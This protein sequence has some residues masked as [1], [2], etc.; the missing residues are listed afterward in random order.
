MKSWKRIISMMIGIVIT[1]TPFNSYASGKLVKSY[2]DKDG[3]YTQIVD[4][5]FVF[6][7]GE[8]VR[9]GGRWIDMNNA[10]YFEFFQFDEYGKLTKGN[11]TDRSSGALLDSRLRTYKWA[12][13][14][15]EI[16]EIFNGEY[17]SFNNASETEYDSKCTF[18]NAD[19]NGV[20][21]EYSY[22]KDEDGLRLST[23]P[24]V[25]EIIKLKWAEG[26][27]AAY[28]KEYN[29]LKELDRYLVVGIDPDLKLNIL[30]F[31]GDAKSKSI[32]IK[33]YTKHSHQLVKK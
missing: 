27:T 5:V 15:D 1:S 19:E 26:K 28:Y 7:D 12:P 9:N 10:G 24:L 18:L 22:H 2:E 29:K 21:L 17:Y 14:D 6:D 31:E 33:R 8:I 25:K 3:I 16:Y 13:D 11:M 20:T 32:H 30:E 4:D 23:A